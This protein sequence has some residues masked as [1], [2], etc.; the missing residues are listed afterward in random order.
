MTDLCLKLET[1]NMLQIFKY[2]SFH[3][4]TNINCRDV[5]LKNVVNIADMSR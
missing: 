3:L 1:V 2:Q 5:Q 4:K